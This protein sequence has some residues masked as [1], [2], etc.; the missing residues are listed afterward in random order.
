MDWD[1]NLVRFNK[2][3]EVTMR[4]SII[5]VNVKWLVFTAVVLAIVLALA[6]LT[7][8]FAS[9]LIFV[10]G[11]IGIAILAVVFIISVPL[12]SIAIVLAFS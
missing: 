5:F 2:K 1:Q 10:G 7:F 6:I 9:V 3:G 11:V 4:G 12:L 8:A